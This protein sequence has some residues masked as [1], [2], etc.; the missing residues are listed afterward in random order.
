MPL[1]PPL[2]GDPTSAYNQ[3][4][5]QAGAQARSSSSA[6]TSVWGLGQLYG[7]PV[8]LGTYQVGNPI[9]DPTAGTDIP[10]A[11][12][13]PGIALDT[14]LGK[15]TTT[16]GVFQQVNRWWAEQAEE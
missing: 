14:D 9:L 12:G 10:R 7:Q 16:Q 3:G 4:T 13:V 8:S 1:P 5:A 11:G 2:Y 15:G 6:A